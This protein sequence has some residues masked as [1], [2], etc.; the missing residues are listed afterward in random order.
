MADTNLAAASTLQRE[1]DAIRGSKGWKLLNLY[2][3]LRGRA[4]YP[5]ARLKQMSDRH[6]SYEHWIK[7]V[8][9]RNYDGGRDTTAKANFQYQP[10]ISVVT[11]VYNVPIDI[12]ESAIRS[13]RKQHYEHWEL[14]V[15]D[16]ASPNE[17]VR[18]CLENWAKQDARIKVTFSD[19][20]E[21]ICRAS[22]R[23]LELAT[24]E[25][26]GFLDHD[27]ELSPDALYE[28]VKLL[29]EDPQVDMIY[30]DEDKLDRHGRRVAPF[31]K[32]DWSP[33]Y[34]LACMYTCH[35]AVYRR[36]LLE[37]LG[38]FR[39]GFD[40]SQDYDLVLRLSE[41]TK[42]IRHIPKVLYHWR[43]VE[44]SAATVPGAKPYTDG[45][46]KKALTEHLMRRQIPGEILSGDA[47][48]SYRIRFRLGD[49]GTVSIVVISAGQGDILRAC[50]NSIEKKTLYP[51]YE[52]VVVEAQSFESDVRQYLLSTSY[53]VVT[54]DEGLSSR[55]IN[56]AARL[57]RGQYL[58]FLHDDTEVIAKDWITSMLGFCGQEEIGVV[59][60]KL[61]YRNELIQH[62][63]MVLG[64]KCLAGHPFRNFPR[65]APLHLRNY[66]AVSGACM[67][68]RKSVFEALGGFDEELG[69]KS[70]DVDFC[71][72]ARMAGYRIVWTPWAELYHDDQP[73]RERN[74]PQEVELLKKRWGRS[75][76]DDP[77]YNTNLT[78]R[79]EDLG[80]R[81][82]G[83]G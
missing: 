22:N 19:R 72:K 78:L 51:N 74:S 64:L 67:M 46:A 15:C 8:E 80:Y 31:F 44:G 55:M 9:L 25:F 83:K 34:M 79:H 4:Q 41:R 29:Q 32:P 63:G 30:S 57:A 69:A 62:A 17:D 47:P 37:E 53:R 50:I 75:L 18:R 77:Y 21:G 28:V 42:R 40:G 1:L 45:T 48:G 82:G 13:V 81:T 35:F 12:L 61:I 3:D 59:G 58:V 7:H 38:G 43:M 71:L 39:T 54:F 52:I 70:S 26:V 11:P 66:S 5:L 24:G 23:A 76:T 6:L 20:N 68:V 14:C 56:S 73:W 10:T 16:D 2:R 36:R 60:A 65:K 27:D 33:E 49:V